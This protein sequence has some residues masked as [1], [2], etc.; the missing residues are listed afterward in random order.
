MVDDGSTDNTY[1]KLA[2]WWKHGFPNIRILNF[3]ENRGRLAA[4]NLGM[5]AA[6]NE[7][8]C[9]LDSDDEYVS[10]YL[11]MMAKAIVEKP[12]YK[13]FNFGAVVYDEKELKSYLRDTFRP[14]LANGNGG[15]EPFR[16]GAIGAGSFIYAREAMEY[17][18]RFPETRH[19]YGSDDSFPALATKQ[20]PEIEALYGRN[21]SGEWRPFGNPWGD[22]W[23]YFFVLT[24][25]Y[26][27]CPLDIHP[28][29]QHVRHL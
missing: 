17:A 18:G 13:V 16:S 1:A 21:E 14:P 23:Y 8:I 19:P 3:Q 27:S 25:K 2:T 5:D 9:W 10:T 26:V 28:Y 15:H 22:D 12:D 24:R 6:T 29:I 4:R 7:W 20:H 11:E